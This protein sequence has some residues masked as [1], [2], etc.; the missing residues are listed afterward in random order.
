MLTVAA[1]PLTEQNKQKEKE[2]EM[3]T[4]SL[5]TNREL[6]LTGPTEYVSDFK[7]QSDCT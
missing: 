4:N 2:I 3:T 6:C 1:I 7:R 5:L